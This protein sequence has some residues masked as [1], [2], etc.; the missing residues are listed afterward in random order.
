MKSI[1]KSINSSDIEQDLETYMPEKSDNFSLLLEIEVGIE[2]EEGAD[3]FNITICTPK[4]IMENL[5]L[6]DS[7]VG[8]YHIIVLNYN[9]K[10]L[11][12]QLN[13]LMCIQGLNWQEISK[14]LSYIGHWEFMDYHGEISKLK[15]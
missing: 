12:Q 1:I 14:R 5:S 8:L 15:Q 7:L 3:L 2:G 6:D 9:F 10:S 4:W 13:Q 11:V